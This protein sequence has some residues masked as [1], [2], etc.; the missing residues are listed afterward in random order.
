VSHTLHAKSLRLERQI[1]GRG[2]DMG[3]QLPSLFSRDA[4]AKPE[5]TC[6]Y[7]RQGWSANT[8]I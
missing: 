5:G 8:H 4:V 6:A 1:G 7:L 2:D 3:T